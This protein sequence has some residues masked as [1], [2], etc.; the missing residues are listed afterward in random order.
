MTWQQAFP[1][2]YRSVKSKGVA[3]NSLRLI[4]K[5]KEY[6]EKVPN[7]TEQHIQAITN[8]IIAMHTVVQ[9]QDSE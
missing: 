3:I 4:E 9:E 8:K 5:L 1:K 2:I 6:N 7:M